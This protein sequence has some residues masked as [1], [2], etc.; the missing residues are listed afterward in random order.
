MVEA[1]MNMP[2]LDVFFSLP[3]NSYSTAARPAIDSW[4]V[5]IPKRIL[6]AFGYICVFKILLFSF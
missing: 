1:K 4:F 2:V 6:N 3:E 5:E